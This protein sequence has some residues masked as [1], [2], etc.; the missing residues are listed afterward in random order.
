MSQSL[1]QSNPD[2]HLDTSHQR[3]LSALE[4]LALLLRHKIFLLITTIVIAGIALGVTLTL[5]NWYDATVNF[6]PPSNNQSGVSG[7]LGNVSSALKD[8]GLTKL[9]GKSSESYSYIVILQSRS[10]LDSLITRFDLAKDYN[11]PDSMRDEIRTVLK[12]NMEVSYM[13]DGNYTMTF[14]STNPNKAADMANTALTIANSISRS[15]QMQEASA[16]RVYM[17]QR[18]QNTEEVLNRIGDSLQKFS[19]KNLVF[20]PVDQAKALTSAL[21]DLKAAA[22]KQE[23]VVQTYKNSYGEDDPA[24]KLQQKTLEDIRGQVN[25]AQNEPG[26]GGNFSMRDAMDVGIPYMRLYTEFEAMSKVKGFLMPML[27]QARL[28]EFKQTP[29]MYVLDK[30]IAPNKKSKPKRSLIVG[31]AALGALL[32]SS[33]FVLLRFRLQSLKS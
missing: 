9:G 28:D 21:A 4:F 14:S 29:L 13:P 26:F 12:S 30:A 17:E 18:L 33:L 32:L 6:V 19:K 1:M 25:K 24:T 10:F 3:P 7:M 20:S 31:G 22:I 16:N 27:E 15:I 8:I 11:I 5:P 23:I 2:S